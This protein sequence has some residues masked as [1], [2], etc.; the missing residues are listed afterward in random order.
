MAAPDDFSSGATRPSGG[1]YTGAPP[2][3]LDLGMT[4]RGFTPE[5]RLFGR[6]VLRRM[7]GRGGMG[8]VWLAWD[9]QLEI[10]VAIKFLPEILIHDRAAISELK[11]E[12]RKSLELTH[13]HIVRIHS[14]LQDDTCA[15]ISMEYVD[16]NTLSNLRLDQPNQVFEADT[17]RLW[18]GQLCQALDYA[19]RIAQVVHRD[20]KPANLMVN[21]KGSLKVAD[22]G[23]ARSVNDSASRMTLSA[24]GGSSGTLV[25]MSPQQALGL[26]TSVQDDVY[27]IGATL[28][29]LLTGKPPFHS[30]DILHQLRE[31]TPPSIQQRREEFAIAGAAIPKEWEETVA[32]CLAKE[33]E[34]RPQG[35]AEVAQRL[36]LDFD[37]ATGTHATRSAA[38]APTTNAA[39]QTTSGSNWWDSIGGKLA[40]AGIVLVC[41]IGLAVGVLSLRGKADQV[42][43]A[44]AGTGGLIVRTTPP[45]ATV[46]LGGMAAK[47][48]PA[49][50]ESMPAVSHKV[51][52]SLPGYKPVEQDVTV[53]K[54]RFG[55]IAFDLQPISGKV[56]IMTGSKDSTYELIGDTGVVGQGSSPAT[57]ANLPPGDY[58][59]RISKPGWQ[60]HEETL[61][62]L[63]DQ[64]APVRFEF[65]T[66]EISVTSEPPS[67]TI[68]LDGQPAG[69]TPAVLKDI[70]P[71]THEITLSLEGHFTENDPVSVEPRKQNS[72][73]YK[74][75]P[76][77]PPAKGTAWRNSLGMRFVPVGDTLCC[78]WETRVRDF[79]AFVKSTGYNADESMLSI[80]ATAPL[81][82]G[83]TW[84]K[85]QYPQT[86]FHP[87]AGVNWWDAQ[88]FCAWLTKKEQSEGLLP[89]SVEYRMPTDAEWS[90]AAGTSTYPWG[91]DWP[92]T[93]NAANI[94]GTETS[95]QL[96]A[97][98][99]QS[100]QDT[101][102]CTAPVG[103][104]AP[105]ALGIYDLGGNVWEYC[106]DTF[107]RE[108]NPEDIYR[109][110]P[111]LDK[112]VARMIADRTL[113]AVV[114]G[115]SWE[116]G[117]PEFL[118]TT[119]R[120][121]GSIAGRVDTRGFRCVLSF[122][123]LQQQ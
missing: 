38:G 14:F 10:E 92:P 108:M 80:T 31:M 75:D 46:T 90:Q 91:N 52:V 107:R 59:I 47:I 19:H 18:A 68:L 84:A 6:F 93:K 39:T 15:G 4:V 85:Q 117:Q 79:A 9:E 33:P 72:L 74:L 49:T 42:A 53:P 102:P 24:A 41:M 115:G 81:A 113:A 111:N 1:G 73:A 40:I 65:A 104:G 99:L 61:T 83:F 55:D 122:E 98:P 23:I 30:G 123:K 48:A 110:F 28:F 106:M 86:V 118:N 51:R 26:P 56:D 62:V 103:S 2:D 29:H 76:T 43:V 32:A 71:G 116:T 45:G 22:F 50:F 37:T 3:D 97:S 112:A 66:G 20:L 120:A 101:T 16:G 25:Y 44:A 114:R 34:Q 89:S 69:Q 121:P 27:A 58:K 12:T 60:T 21:A 67:A 63:P 13:H 105:N 82:K 57:I 87:V 35:A 70:Q 94:A 7:L 88:K 64:S 8:V 54:D 95:T 36:G 119:Y 11:R 17:L 5:M 78:I 100:H 109:K 96:V 77:A